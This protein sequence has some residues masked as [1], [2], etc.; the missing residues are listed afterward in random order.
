METESRPR[1]FYPGFIDQPPPQH[2]AP[3]WDIG[4]ERRIDDGRTLARGL[5]WFSIGLGLFE[6]FGA[7]RLTSFLGIDDRHATLIRA[8]GVREIATGVGIMAERTP[9]VGVWSRVAGDALDM[10]TLGLAFRRDEPRTSR[11]ALAMIAV[12][13]AAAVDIACARQLT[14]TRV[15]MNGGRQDGAGDRDRSAW[16]RL[17]PP[18]DGRYV[19]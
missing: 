17:A 6:L 18:S 2:G 14:R 5:A 19:Q 16:S 11:V 8:Y 10:A 12:A 15:R 3:G 1:S 7:R 4:P 13:G 9:A